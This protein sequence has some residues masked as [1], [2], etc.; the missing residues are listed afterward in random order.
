MRKGREEEYFFHTFKIRVVEFSIETQLHLSVKSRA[1]NT[2]FL[3]SHC[4]VF[5]QQTPAALALPN[6][7]ITEECVTCYKEAA[8][9]SHFGEILRKPLSGGQV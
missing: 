8:D 9:T 7:R 5:T 2:N 1:L 4:G 3:K 6:L